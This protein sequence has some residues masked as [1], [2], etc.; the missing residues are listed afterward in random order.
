MTNNSEQPAEPFAGRDASTIWIPAEARGTA[1]GRGRLQGARILVVGAGSQACD[2]PDPPIG[3]GRAIALL[4]AREGA[5][6]ACADKDESAAMQTRYRIVQEGCAAT[7]IVADVTS[8]QDCE[9][10]VTNAIRD[11]KGIDGLVLNIGVGLGR[12]LAATS[13]E[14]WDQVFAVN[15]RA[16][17]L[18]ARAVLPHLDTGA[19]I[20]FVSSAAGIRPG[21]NVPAYDS[22]K[23]GLGG[24]CRH[25]AFEG[26]RRGIRANIIAPGLIDTPLGRAASRGRPLRAQTP[27]PLGRQGTAWEVAYAT[28]FLLSGEASYITG[29]ILVVDGGLSELR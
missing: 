18:I 20:V 6:V 15:L 5:A 27:V 22:S 24:L 9:R 25:V 21:T 1:S 7:V 4:C 8:E 2:E 16:H 11:L 26:S 17:F 14:Q 3:N 12:G 23:A 28:V 29:Q 19:S 10:M 13:A